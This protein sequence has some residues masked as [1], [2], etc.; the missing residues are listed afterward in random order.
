[1]RWIVNGAVIG[2]QPTL[3]YSSLPARSVYLRA[4]VLGDAHVVYTQPFILRHVDDITGDG[5]LGTDDRTACK[6]LEE[7]RLASTPELVAACEENP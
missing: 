7:G 4:E 3:S 5:R 2:T 1:V 6:D